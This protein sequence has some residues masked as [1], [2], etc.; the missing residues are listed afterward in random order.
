MRRV[1]V[2]LVVLTFFSGIYAYELKGRI[3]DSRGEPVKVGIVL[4]KKEGSNKYLKSRLNSNGEFLFKDLPG[5]KYSFKLDIFSA[6]K[7]KRKIEL[8]RDMD[9][10]LRVRLTALDRALIFTRELSDIAW[11]T[12]M[13]ILLLGT[14]IIL[15][16]ATGWVQIRK[17]ASAFREVF[18]GALHRGYLGREE[19]D[20][21]PFAALMTALAATVGNGNIAGVATAIATGGPGAPFWMWVAGIFGMATK[22]AEG[23]LGV[24]FR[25]KMPTGEMAG[26][27]MYY[28]RYGIRWKPAAKFLGALFA[29][30]ASITALLGTGNMAQSN[31]M[32]LAFKTQFGIPAWITGAAITAMVGIVVIGGIKKIGS[33]SE[34]LVPAMI[35]LYVFGGTVVILANFTKIPQ[36]FLLIFESAFS[37]KAVG[38]ALVGTTVAQAI[39]IGVRRGVLSNES[40]LGSAAIAQAASR[41]PEPVYNGLIAMTGTF[42]DTIFVNTFTTLTI[43]L[44]GAYLYTAAYGSS[45][46]LTSTA[47]TIAAFESAIPHPFGGAIIALASFL[48]GY[49]TLIAWCYY[50]E[51]SFEY[52]AGSRVVVPYRLV[53]ISLTFIGAIVQGPYLNIIWYTGDSANALMALPNLVALLFLVNVVRKETADKLYRRNLW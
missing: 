11:G 7:L 42:I 14:G 38:G 39:S 35:V 21:S 12:W 13:I 30:S 33:V 43:I 26:G 2:I 37:L 29:I 4:L 6:E 44:S 5:G 19:G 51:K 46:G 15:T 52:I 24:K 40:G 27:P 45:K 53:F 17:L 20:I 23:F 3:C 10:S 28:A 22:Y 50:G 34:K 8:N 49:S 32:A 47:L 41:S 1:G 16:L 18:R 9:L 48:F 25:K 31:S 36:A